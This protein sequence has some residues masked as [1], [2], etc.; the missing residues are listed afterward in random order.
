[1]PTHIGELS[2]PRKSPHFLKLRVAI[3]PFLS[4]QVAVGLS[5]G[6]DSLSLVA[7]ARAE[8]CDVH[9][10]CIDH[11][12]QPGSAE[13]S[14]SA[15]ETAQSMGCT[16][17]IQ[18]VKVAQGNLEAQARRSRYEVFARSPRP[19]WVAHTMDDQAE[20]YLLG[21]LRGN[22][23]GMLPVTQLGTT[24]LVRPLL[25]VRRADTHGACAELGLSPWQD[26]HNQNPA[27]R[28][29]AVRQHTLPHLS[30]LI[31]SDAVPAIAQAAERAA[32]LQDFVRGESVAMDV[33]KLRAV[34]PAVRQASIAEFLHREVGQVSWVVV[35]EVER[36][37]TD[38]HGQ[39]PIAV[40]GHAGVRRN[41]SR[42]AGKL[43]ID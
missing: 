6:A 20:T 12:L 11:G 3:R 31:A 24:S 7:A 17:E 36:L 15:A 4:A 16:S 22:P 1:M 27:F 39:G 35:R 10:I 32:L 40:G 23:A 8:G 28:R 19:V 9:A 42:V 26:P 34:H 25:T 38:W 2:L 30:E 13:V 18:R 37:V 5:G 33:A 43:V 14:A 21:A 41:V 29:V